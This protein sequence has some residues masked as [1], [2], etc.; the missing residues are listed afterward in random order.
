M[1]PNDGAYPSNA[2]RWLPHTWR[3]PGS[4][5]RGCALMGRAAIASSWGRHGKAESGVGMSSSGWYFDSPRSQEEAHRTPQGQPDQSRS[6]W[7]SFSSTKRD[8][9]RCRGLPRRRDSAMECWW[10]ISALMDGLPVAHGFLPFRKSRNPRGRMNE[11]PAY[12]TR[13]SLRRRT[14]LLGAAAN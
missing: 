12:A 4:G 2:A 9:S 1:G 6:R 14:F 13:T 5:L 11:S 8:A 7:L 3:G 10:R